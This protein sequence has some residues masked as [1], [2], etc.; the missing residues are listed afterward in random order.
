MSAGGGEG[1]TLAGSTAAFALGL[2]LAVAPASAEIRDGDRDLAIADCFSGGPSVLLNRGDGSF[3][4]P[5]RTRSG[6][7]A[8]TVAAGDFNGDR[9]VDLVSVAY[10]EGGLT[11]FSGRGDGTFSVGEEYGTGGFVPQQIVVADLDRDGDRDL[12]VLN[13]RPGN[14]ALLLGRGDGSF[15]PGGAVSLGPV[16]ISLLAAK[17]NRDRFPDI[18]VT[19][20]RGAVDVLLGKGDGSFRRAAPHPVGRN[21]EFVARGD[22]NGDR[23]T[24]LVTADSFAWPEGQVSLLYGRG[25]GTFRRRVR[26]Y[27][28]SEDPMLGGTGPPE[29]PAGIAV[30]DFD[31]DGR[32]DLAVPG[33]LAS[34]VWILEQVR[35]SEFEQAGKH[36]VATHPEPLLADDFNGDCLPVA[37]PGNVPAVPGT[38]GMT[39]V[40]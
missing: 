14:V 21:P 16:A 27:P 19:D 17:L 6:Q 24:D 34:Q 13:T 40:S 2:V 28:Y 23:I 33:F 4:P 32:R 9:R 29:G 11:V 26:L 12:A 31:L 30:A 15:K 7:D 37:V 36:S 1:V 5:S 20:S 3:G 38:P 39:Q 8:C 22:V 18:A 35:G 10:L 25:D